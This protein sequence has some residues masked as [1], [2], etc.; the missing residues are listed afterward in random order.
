MRVP[1]IHTYIHTCHSSGKLEIKLFLNTDIDIIFSVCN[2][3]Y[4]FDVFYLL[5]S[6]EVFFLERKREGV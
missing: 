6:N 5:K 4:N 2:F 3:K 1:Y